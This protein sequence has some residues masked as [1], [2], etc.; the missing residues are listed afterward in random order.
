MEQKKVGKSIAFLRKYYGMTQQELG[1][2]IGVSFKTISKWENGHGVPD[3]SLLA[4][5]ADVLDIDIES[6]LEGNLT[7]MDLNW[8]GVLLLEYPEEIFLDS[9]MDTLRVVEFQV[10]FFLLAGI[11]KI[12]IVGS[13]SDMKGVGQFLVPLYEVIGDDIAFVS[14]D[15][16][17]GT[18][19]NKVIAQ[20]NEKSGVF[21]INGLDFIYGKDLTKCFRRIMYDARKPYKLS[22]F[23]CM[24][25]HMLFYP[26]K[27]FHKGK[28]GEK[29]LSG[30]ISPKVLERGIVAF[31]IRDKSHL[32]AASNVMHVLENCMGEKV[33]DLREIAL[34]RGISV[35]SND[36]F[37]A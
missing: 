13:N 37:D 24:G 12:T 27:T 30:E 5:L 2:R 8:Q 31:P 20:I 6:I 11:R 25:L 22:N 19:L 28:F 23:N 29:N 33:G 10:S 32:C 17:L 18:Q 7:H 3:I 35:N 14:T 16:D 26:K 9:L 4:K 15:E 36:L 1:E 21:L 34:R